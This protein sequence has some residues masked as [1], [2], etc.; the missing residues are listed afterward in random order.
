MDIIL[1]NC[2]RHHLALAV[3]AVLLVM[4]FSCGNVA[5]GQ[6]SADTA[7]ATPQIVQPIDE[8]KLLQLKGNTHPLARAEFDEGAVAPNL[9][10]DRILLVLQRSPEREAALEQFIKEQL[11]PTSPNFHRWLSPQ[12]FGS[13]YGPADDDIQKVTNWLTAHGFT[14]NSVSKEMCIRDRF[15][16]RVRQSCPIYRRFRKSCARNRSTAGSFTISIIAIRSPST[17]LGWAAEC[18]RAAGSI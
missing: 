2:R 12:E 14:V 6:V 15:Y 7:P 8:G 3:R 18:S 17:C 16:P 5:F 10:M 4:V 13:Q 11:D 9:S 1:S